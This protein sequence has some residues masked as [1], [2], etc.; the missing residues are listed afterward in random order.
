M[1][2][3]DGVRGYNLYVFK[4]WYQ[5]I[6]ESAQP[7]KVEFKISKDV[8]A[9]VYGFALVLTIKLLSVGSHG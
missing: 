8:P 3:D 6:L 7:I 9:G 4:I 2:Q 1:G 5:K